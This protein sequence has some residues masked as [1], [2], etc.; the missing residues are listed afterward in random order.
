MSILSQLLVLG[1]LADYNLV[2]AADRKLSAGMDAH[3]GVHSNDAASS[4]GSYWLQNRMSLKNLEI[5][6]ASD[7]LDKQKVRQ[8][9][10]AGFKEQAA[11]KDFKVFSQNGEDGITAYILTCIGTTNKYYLEI[12]TEA[13]KECNTRI[14]RERYKWTGL[15]LDGAYSDPS[16]NLRQEVLTAENVEA[17]LHKYDVPLA[18][19]FDL[20]SIDIDLNTFWVLREV[21]EA[22][23]R[24]RMLVTEIN[25]SFLPNQSYAVMYMPNEVWDDNEGEVLGSCYYG[26]SALAFER[27]CR[28]FGYSFVAVD[29]LGINMFFVHDEGALDGRPLGPSVTELSHDSVMWWHIHTPCANTLW[30]SVGEGV[31]F[32]SPQW[33]HVLV[34]VI[35]K[36][37]VESGR[38]GLYEVNLGV[39]LQ[40]V[41]CKSMPQ[42]KQ[43]TTL[44]SWEHLDRRLTCRN[45]HAQT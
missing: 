16:I 45:E 36:H 40:V 2:A 41:G 3:T 14:L 30:L 5:P 37:D 23:Y 4:Q 43:G 34:P 39:E 15:M 44:D 25:R 10:T 27:M 32:D 12:G 17:V 22:G 26:A 28:H 21:L 7:L 24:P 38:R 20:M 9:L 6:D 11:P 8:C 19:G 13:G 31:P 29:S 35:M 33:Q 42:V 18:G 1:L